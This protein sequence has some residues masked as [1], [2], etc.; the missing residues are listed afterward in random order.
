MYLNRNSQNKVE[1]ADGEM[2]TEQQLVNGWQLNAHMPGNPALFD[3]LFPDEDQLK[4][5][6]TTWFKSVAENLLQNQQTQMTNLSLAINQTFFNKVVQQEDDIDSGLGT[7]GKFVPEIRNLA[8]G[9]FSGKNIDVGGLWDGGLGM[10]E[11]DT[12]RNGAEPSNLERVERVMT[13]AIGALSAITAINPIIGAV[14]AAGFMI[15][16]AAGKEAKRKE[17]REVEKDNEFYGESLTPFPMFDKGGD[18]VAVDLVLEAMPK[19]DWTNLFLPRYKPAERWV[20]ALRQTGVEFFPGKETGGWGEAEPTFNEYRP[21]ILGLGLIPGTQQVTGTLQSRLASERIGA[22]LSAMAEGYRTDKGIDSVWEWMQVLGPKTIGLGSLD[23]GDYYPSSAQTMSFLWGHIQTQGA[24][25]NP[26][27]YKIDCPFVD[28]QWGSYCDG[29]W[30]YLHEMCSWDSYNFPMNGKSMEHFIKHGEHSQDRRKML[31]AEHSCVIACLLGVYRCHS[32]ELGGGFLNTSP[33][34]LQGL[35]SKACNT[36]FNSIPTDCRQN[37]YDAYVHERIV[38]LH[39]MQYEML[40]ASLVSAYVSSDFIA[41]N[42]NGNDGGQAAQ[43]MTKLKAMRTKLLDRPDQWKFLVEAN[44]PQD[45][46]HEGNDW[47]GLLKD[48][49]AFEKGPL[50]LAGSAGQA[51][52]EMGYGQ[53]GMK[54]QAGFGFETPAPPLMQLVGRI[55]GE[56]LVEAVASGRRGTGTG[57]AGGGKGIILLAA[58]ALG[59]IAMSKRRR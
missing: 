9:S 33:P 5:E 13:G 23:T 4:G 53:G 48:A 57:S 59:L 15:G 40:S 28:G 26:D 29:A 44:V 18:E 51:G 37:I 3:S 52:S 10:L 6:S 38:E 20:G 34:Y 49:G 17:L 39:K 36:G 11:F 56:E 42:G 31:V 43:M 25:G 16:K 24:A 45:E 32:K 55:P 12:D 2:V 1:N 22:A 21:G 14:V 27:L 8:Y 50:G 19:S 41:F 30:E 58:A 7:L 54:L 35:G 47:Y 46:D